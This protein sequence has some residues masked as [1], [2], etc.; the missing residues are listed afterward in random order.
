[1]QLPDLS[2]LAV[3]AL[4]WATFFVLRTFLF[5]P[6][7][8]ILKERDEAAAQATQSL[9]AALVRE[10]EALQTIDQKMTEARRVALALHESI[11][12]EAAA[13]RQAALEEARDRA[14]ATIAAGDEKLSSEVAAARGE[15]EGAA[16]S[17]AVEIAGLALGR[18]VA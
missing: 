4:F 5:R 13:A 14:R 15:L 7:G 1:M 10:R 18:K 8:S 16:R 11:R 3:M 2:L 9:E 17:T 6:L 12:A